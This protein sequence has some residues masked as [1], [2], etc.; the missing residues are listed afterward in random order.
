MNKKIMIVDDDKEFLDELRE[1][2]SLSGYDLIAVNDP[3]LVLEMVRSEKPDVLLLDLKMQKM[4][5]FQVADELKYLSESAHMP[6][7]AI[8]AFI[9]NDYAPMLNICGIRCHLNKPFRPLDVIAK[10]EEVLGQGMA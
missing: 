8:S 10:I 4:S 7:I 5:G 1:T 2:L 3:T 9:K 6:I